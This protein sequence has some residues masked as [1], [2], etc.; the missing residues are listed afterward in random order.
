MKIIMNRRNWKH[1]IALPFGFI[2]FLCVWIIFIIINENV[3]ISR[4]K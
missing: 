2:A 1:Y 4:E 3:I